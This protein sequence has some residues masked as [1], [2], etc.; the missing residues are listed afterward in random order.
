MLSILPSETRRKNDYLSVYTKIHE[1]IWVQ[2]KQPWQLPRKG[3]G[4]GGE[5]VGTWVGRHFSLYTPL[6]LLS[7][8]LYRYIT[9]FFKKEIK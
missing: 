6:F 4:W 8:E 7:L 3:T 9:A 1:K 2:K 5:E